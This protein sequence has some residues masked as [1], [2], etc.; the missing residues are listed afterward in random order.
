MKLAEALQRRADINSKIIKL[1]S[2]MEDSV[3][4][5]ENEEPDFDIAKLL[6]EHDELIEERTALI[7]E[8]NTVN[9]KTVDPETGKTVAQLI[10]LRDS[11]KTRMATYQQIVDKAGQKSWRS[12]G[13]EIRTVTTVKAKDIQKK[14]DEMAKEFRLVDNKIQMLNWATDLE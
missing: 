3:L 5:Q 9:N 14:V 7:D 13:M 1:R 10:S 2:N 8:I 11:L 12:S 4:V 6:K